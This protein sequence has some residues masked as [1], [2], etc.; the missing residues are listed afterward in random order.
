MARAFDAGLISSGNQQ[1]QIKADTFTNPLYDGADPWVVRHDET[2]YSCSTGPGGCIEVWKS[3][4]M[5]E[6]G[7]RSVV[8]TPPRYGWNRAEVWAPELHFIRGLW[9]IYYAASDGQN[10]NHRMGVL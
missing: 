10:A 2:F 1:F 6:R 5:V 8:W 7:E 9:Y 4:S 3:Q